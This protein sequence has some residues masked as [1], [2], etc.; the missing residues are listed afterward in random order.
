M[1]DQMV[2]NGERVNEYTTYALFDCCHL[3]KDAISIVIKSHNSGINVFTL[4]MIREL[5]SRT[6][7][8]DKTRD[9]IVE[10]IHSGVPARFILEGIVRRGFAGKY[11][12]WKH[13]ALRELG[14][15]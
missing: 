7:M 5:E 2:S 14:L 11:R 13:E 1:A 10:A 15:K 3:F 9:F 6:P 12:R 8:P 4:E